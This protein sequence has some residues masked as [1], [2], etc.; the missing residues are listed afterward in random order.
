MIRGLVRRF[1]PAVFTLAAVA[2]VGGQAPPPPAASS[3]NPACIRLETYLANLDRGNGEAPRAP[4]RPGATRKRRNASSANST[5]YRRKASAWVAPARVS[6]CSAAGSRRNAT[7]STIR[8]RPC[9]RT[10]TASTWVSSSSRETDPFL[11]RSV[12]KCWPSSPRTIADRNI[13]PRRRPVP[14]DCPRHAVRQQQRQQRQQR[15]SERGRW[16][17]TLRSRHVP[18][19]L[20]AHLRRILLSGFL[21]DGAEQVCRRR[22]RL[23]AHVPGRG[24]LALQLSQPRR[25]H[26]A[27]SVE[28]AAAVT[29]NCRPRSAI[30]RSSTRP[31]VASRQARAGPTR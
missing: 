10:S 20:R 7:D 4:S 27:G 26:G 3:T 29:A 9:G 30:A 31:A 28:P 21:C 25:G 14:P 16:N 17:R 2:L 13:A 15:Q 1:V 12:N 18:H 6:S 24:S 19:R 5:A 22:A 23:P 11:M 8:C